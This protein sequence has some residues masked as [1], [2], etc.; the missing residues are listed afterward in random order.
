MANPNDPEFRIG[1]SKSA[2]SSVG[3]LRYPANM[4]HQ[5]YGTH[6]YMM[7]RSY[8][9]NDSRLT[10]RSFSQ[11]AL[12]QTQDPEWSCALYIPPGAL[13]TGFKGNYANL[14]YGGSAIEHL[15]GAFATDKSAVNKALSAVRATAEGTENI[16]ADPM[17]FISSL[18]AVMSEAA[19]ETINA[20]IRN[21]VVAKQIFAAT[22]VA[23]NQHMALVYNGP[24]EFRSHQFAFNFFPKNAT[25]AGIF[26]TIN[27]KFKKSMKPKVNAQG[28]MRTALDSAWWGYPNLFKLDFYTGHGKF[29]GMDIQQSALTALDVEYDGAEST[30]AF[31]KDGQPVGTKLNLTFQET[32]HHVD[33]MAVSSIDPVS[34]TAEQRRGGRGDIIETPGERNATLTGEAA[35]VKSGRDTYKGPSV[36]VPRTG[37][38]VADPRYSNRKIWQWGNESLQQ[39]QARAGEQG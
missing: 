24:G 2:Q 3:A 13:K 9:V 34:S 16:K 14:E 27:E 32:I 29:P 22:G 5:E 21:N 39:A 31:H 28:N 18:T 1:A 26:H 8:A 37:S 38:H 15:G 30:V 33:A 23:A 36:K 19:K 12:W 4:M 10:T 7:I 35:N 11:G 20:T 6:P 25:E 17:S